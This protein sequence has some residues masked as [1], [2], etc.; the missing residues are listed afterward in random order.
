[1]SII[2]TLKERRAF[3]EKRRRS[4]EGVALNSIHHP[5][6]DGVEPEGLNPDSLET[7]EIE[8]PMTPEQILRSLENGYFMTHQEQAETAQ[9]IRKLQQE[10]LTLL[11]KTEP[12]GKI[13]TLAEMKKL[14]NGE[15]IELAKPEQS[16]YSDIVSNGGLDPRN[17]FDAQ[18]EQ[19]PVAW[20]HPDCA[21]VCLACLIELKVHEEYGQQGLNYLR[22]RVQTPRTEWVG[23]TQE[24]RDELLNYS[25]SVPS[26]LIDW[27]EEKLKEKNGAL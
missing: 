13:P 22:K 18:P 8:I 24:A 16:N 25:T 19:E 2:P 1:M 11:G 9:Y 23:L 26:R 21:G 17:K 5:E 20:H 3:N 15:P 10:S 12:V 4:R 7:I 27:T 6:G 14:L